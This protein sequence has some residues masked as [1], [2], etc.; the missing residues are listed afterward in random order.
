MAPARDI[1]LSESQ[2]AQPALL[3]DRR[4]AITV[5]ADWSAGSS[6]P[7]FAIALGEGVKRDVTGEELI[8][9]VGFSGGPQLVRWSLV[10]QSL[11]CN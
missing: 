8:W 1:A 9:P 2:S 10:P 7:T 5:G 11:Y 3:P 6:M 4:C